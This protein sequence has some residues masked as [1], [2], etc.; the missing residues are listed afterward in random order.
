M[1]QVRHW[2]VKEN[3]KFTIELPI[4]KFCIV[5]I[6]NYFVC[7]YTIYSD[8]GYSQPMIF[9]PSLL[10]TNLSFNSLPS[11]T[12]LLMHVLKLLMALRFNR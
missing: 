7:F 12:N 9:S 10:I 4:R 8:R 1:G 11:F 3:T 6:L 5:L 2:L